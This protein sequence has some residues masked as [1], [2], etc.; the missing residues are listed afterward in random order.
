MIYD[1][2]DFGI[3]CNFYF[4]H[5]G[6]MSLNGLKKHL[7]HCNKCKKALEKQFGD[8]KEGFPTTSR[9]DIPEGI[10]TFDDFLQKISF[11]ESFFTAN[12]SSLE[13]KLKKRKVK[14]QIEQ[15][16]RRQNM[17]ISSI[18]LGFPDPLKT[19]LVLLFDSLNKLEKLLGKEE[20]NI[21]M[22]HSSMGHSREDIEKN[23]ERIET[24]L[25][26]WFNMKIK[27]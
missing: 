9:Y 3:P 2:S 23:W 22:G 24:I 10:S 11:E 4:E 8:Y 14:I 21:Y 12:K 15:L 26:E 17:C 20:F 6:I 1:E 25:E 16:F 27:K 18:A 5:I 7:I 13:D 19:A